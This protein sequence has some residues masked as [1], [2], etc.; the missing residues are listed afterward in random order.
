MDFDVVLQRY[1]K[2]IAT[3]EERDWLLDRSLKA[4]QRLAKDLQDIRK[5]L[6]DREV[7][8]GDFEVWWKTESNAP[9]HWGTK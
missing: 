3:E 1:L 5:L 7:M 6:E 8:L 4:L 2:G 9:R